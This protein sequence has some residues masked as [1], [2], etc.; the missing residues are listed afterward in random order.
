MSDQA[1][2]CGIKGMLKRDQ[3]V[4]VEEMNEA[5]REQGGNPGGLS[6]DDRKFDQPD[7]CEPSYAS[8]IVHDRDGRD[9]ESEP[10][11]LRVR[12]RLPKL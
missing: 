5:V 4:S 6:R 8:D 10:P 1:K 3:P 9:L 7:C 12:F 11:K 2:R